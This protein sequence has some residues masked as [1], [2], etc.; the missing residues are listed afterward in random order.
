MKAELPAG[1]YIVAVSGGVDSIVLLDLLSK[2]PQLDIV[3]A[4]FDHGMRKDSY[5]DLEFVKDT[6]KKMNLDFYSAQGNLGENASEAQAREARYKF[7]KNV[8]S[9]QNA[10]AIITAHHQDDQVETIIINILR[11]TG[12]KGL[13]SLKDRK[14]VKRPLLN[15]SKSEII[16]YAKKNKIIWREDPTNQDEKYLRNYIRKI[17]PKLSSQD[18]A[19]LLKLSQD[20]SLSDK[21][22]DQILAKLQINKNLL[23]RKIFAGF[24]HKSAK[25]VLASL[26]RAN[27]IELNRKLIEEAVIFCKTAKK[28]KMFSL[29]KTASLI[30]TG[31][32][33][34]IS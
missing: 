24:D 4:H 1:K 5:M 21:S 11:G 25:E 13:D 7:L 26:L 19:K 2:Q 33:I 9:E 22:I 8:A 15:Y 31:E 6:A 32:N 17:L 23:N 16:D 29:N 34:K 27:D 10:D 3:V 28:G 20:S 18:R 12:R 14:D 30:I